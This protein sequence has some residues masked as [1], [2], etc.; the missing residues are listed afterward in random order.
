MEW[1]ASLQCMRPCCQPS[2]PAYLVEKYVPSLSSLSSFSS[3]EELA[4]AVG[5]G[6][7]RV[8]KYLLARAEA[9]ARVVAL[10]RLGVLE[11]LEDHHLSK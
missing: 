5:V 2:K 1:T 8:I 9:N 6:Q 3:Q 11:S 10:K 7:A 4:I